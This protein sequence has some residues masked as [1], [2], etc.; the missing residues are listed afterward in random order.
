MY[1]NCSRQYTT[2]LSVLYIKYIQ[3]TIIYNIF[4]PVQYTTIYTIHPYNHIHLHY[5]IYCYFMKQTTPWNILL[6]RTYYHSTTL[7]LH[8]TIHIYSTLLYSTL[9]YSTL[10][11]P[12]TL[13]S[14]KGSL[15]KFHITTYFIYSLFS[16]IWMLQDILERINWNSYQYWWSGGNIANTSISDDTVFW[17]RGK[18]LKS[19]FTFWI[20]IAC[21]VLFR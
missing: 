16:Q 9:L 20:S 12:T 13:K 7:P 19:V 10:H 3:Y 1:Y 17:K 15:Q 6:H 5:T 8:T 11:T 21:W 4:Y 14:V 18:L 2:L